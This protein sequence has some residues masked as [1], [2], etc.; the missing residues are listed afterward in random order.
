MAF[1]WVMNGDI[2]DF[3]KVYLWWLEI[4]REIVGTSGC[5]RVMML[6]I[7]IDGDFTFIFIGS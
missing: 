7:V 2:G 5:F 1:Y 3:V 4:L 6:M